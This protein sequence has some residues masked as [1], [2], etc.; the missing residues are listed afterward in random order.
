MFGVHLRLIP[1]S[2][3]KHLFLCVSIAL[4]FNGKFFS[5]ILSLL[6]CLFFLTTM[7][8][9]DITTSVIVPAFPGNVEIPHLKRKLRS[10]PTAKL[11]TAVTLVL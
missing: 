4:L 6:F 3:T 8:K 10:I 7:G 9:G 5:F 11:N 1:V 2:E